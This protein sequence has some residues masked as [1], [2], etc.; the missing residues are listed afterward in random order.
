MVADLAVDEDARREAIGRYE[1]DLSRD[2]PEFNAL[3]QLAASFCHTPMAFISFVVGDR[4]LVKSAV[5]LKLRQS[6]LL[7]SFAAFSV[8]RPD[9]LLVVRD[10]RRD[11]RFINHPL[12]ANEPYVRFVAAAPLCAPSGHAIGLISIAD[13]M[14]RGLSES[15]E[16]VLRALADQVMRL[17]EL[18][19]TV[20]RLSSE[21]S[22]R[23]RFER[24]LLT[25]NAKLGVAALED[26][27]TGLSNRRA[28][29]QRLVSEIQRANRLKY[30]LSLLTIDIDQFK[31]I[32]DVW[33]HLVGD[34]VLREVANSLRTTIRTTDFVAR[35]G[36][37]EFS[38]ILPGTDIGGATILGE[39]CRRAVERLEGSRLGISISIGAAEHPGDTRDILDL[40]ARSDL[41]LLNAKRLGR[42]RVVGHSPLTVQP[43]H[44]L[45]AA[46]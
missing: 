16:Q 9:Q 19:H 5:G 27:V 2:D 29:E 26:V 46:H 44:S 7:N 24:E 14:E 36:G 25:T 10:A 43:S 22:E 42:N 39:R 12:V 20:H 11:E 33:G 23:S 13:F 8:S 21:I 40:V 32:N 17:L 4:V 45:S 38:A 28:F 31:R 34:Q 37:D 1:F 18:R 35:V 15:E 30:P 41:S 6:P 3:S